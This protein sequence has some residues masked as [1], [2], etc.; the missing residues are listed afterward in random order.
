MSQEHSTAHLNIDSEESPIQ[1]KS[2]FVAL[3]LSTVMIEI[4]TVV[5]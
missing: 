5:L 3:V 1:Y 2:G 4:P